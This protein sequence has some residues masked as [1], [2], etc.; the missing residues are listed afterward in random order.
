M[1]QNIRHRSMHRRVG[2]RAERP[3]GRSVLRSV[4]RSVVRDTWR[5]VIPYDGPSL[6]DICVLLSRYI[7]LAEAYDK[8]WNPPA[9][10]SRF[11]PLCSPE[12]SRRKFEEDLQR[13]YGKGVE[14]PV[15]PAES[16]GQPEQLQSSAERGRLACSSQRPAE[17]FGSSDKDT[18]SPAPAISTAPEKKDV[19]AVPLIRTASGL[20]G[21]DWSAA[22]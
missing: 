7:R 12:E 21:L 8:K 18:A 20:L 6:N 22:K 13:C 19:V 9:P 11:Q 3:V 5:A 2:R 10:K 17:N 14:K 16:V 4:T 15:R 1:P